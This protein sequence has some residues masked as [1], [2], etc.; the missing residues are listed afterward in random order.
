MQSPPPHDNDG[1]PKDGTAL[2]TRTV[3]DNQESDGD[4]DNS[5]PMLMKK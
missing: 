5:Q 4:E 1:K 2:N 3:D